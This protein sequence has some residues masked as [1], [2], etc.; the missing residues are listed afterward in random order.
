MVHSRKLL[1]VAPFSVAHRERLE[2][3]FPAL[4]VVD[5]SAQRERIFDE[6][7]DADVAY[8]R[9]LPDQIAAAQRLAFIQ[10]PTRGVDAVISEG[11]WTKGVRLATVGDLYSPA[12][13]EHIVAMV[14]AL[15][16]HIP[17]M[18]RRQAART[19]NRDFPPFG[20]L[21]GKTV[22]FVGTGTIAR[23]TAHLLEGFRCRF[24]GVNRTGAAR[25]PIASIRSLDEVMAESDVIVNTLP[26]TSETRGIITAERI[27]M[28]RSDALFI[29]VGRGKTVDE[30]A[31]VEA[32]RAGRLGGAGLDV[33]ETEPLS[34]SSPLWAMPNVLVSCHV[35]GLGV[36]EAE[37]A[38][39]VLAENLRRL[40]DGRPLLHEVDLDAGY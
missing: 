21:S 36:N 34:E 18:V 10:L 25:P 28:M 3:E 6:V 30:A 13:A 37:G 1:L 32:L 19:W 33:F 2:G 5:C 17:V 24:I 40:E 8:G 39:A 38:Y 27:G 12:M 26:L 4:R 20:R 22:G 11:L 35:S 29:N 15:Y 9:L 16:R 23:H 7:G 14:L 31:L